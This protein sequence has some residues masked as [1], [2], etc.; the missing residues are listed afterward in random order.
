MSDERKDIRD[1]VKV[2]IRYYRFKNK[3]TQEDLAEQVDLTDKYIGDIE[4]GEFYIGLERL[5]RIAKAF[6]IP[7]YKLLKDEHN[8]ENLPTRLDEVTKKRKPKRK[9]RY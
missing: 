3:L 7:T 2:N 4:R 8:E 6:N 9:K 1:I 5:E